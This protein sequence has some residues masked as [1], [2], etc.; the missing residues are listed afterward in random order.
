MGFWPPEAGGDP[1]RISARHG[2][3]TWD[4]VVVGAGP[5]GSAAA[6]ACAEGGL[7][8]LCIEEH[9]TIGYP[10]QCAGLLSTSAFEE[11]GVSGESIQNEVSGARMVSDLGGELL[12][13]AGS[14]R[15]TSW[16]G[17]ASTGRWRRERR[18]LEP[19]SSSRPAYQAYRALPSDP[20]HPGA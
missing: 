4:V 9:G 8:T 20:G 10:V 11:C 14:Q 15:P 6:R 2:S 17:A 16:I 3:L 19:S 7:S 12:F 13:D 5:S 1:T 18:M